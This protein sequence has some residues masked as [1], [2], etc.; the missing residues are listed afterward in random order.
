M[1]KVILWLDKHL[2][3]SVMMLL[4]SGIVAIMSLQVFMRYVMQNSLAWPDELTRYFLIWFV[5]LGLAYGIRYQAHLK[6]DILENSVPR[7]KKG[8]IVA[9]DLLLLGFCLYMI[10]PSFNGV[11]LLFSTDQTSPALGIKMYIV[12]SSLLV[13]FLLAIFRLSQKY[14]V[15]IIRKKRNS[16]KL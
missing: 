2:E 14:I 6:V 16:F 1:K 15:L 9:Q 4:L 13:G 3:E 8:L 10:Q 11:N 5:F 7:I 12:Y